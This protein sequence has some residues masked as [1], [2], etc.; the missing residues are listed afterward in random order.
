[1]IPK[2]TN[3][4]ASFR[5]AFRYYLHDKGAETS[6]RVAWTQTVNLHTPDAAKAWK[7]MAYTAQAQ[8]R[9]KEAS[10]QSRAGRKLEKP[11]FAFSLAWHPEQSPSQEHIL[12]TAQKA[13]DALGLGEHEAVIVAHTD[14]PQKHVH[15]I[16]NRVH[17]SAVS[18]HA[19]L[20]RQSDSFPAA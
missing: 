2:I 7:V 3:G 17:A 6:S 11:V 8:E 19:I 20:L 15:V 9:L 18:G 16:V 4:G 5:G 14:E 12:D 1:M 10:G 13:I